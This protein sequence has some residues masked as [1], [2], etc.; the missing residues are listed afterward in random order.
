MERCCESIDEICNNLRDKVNDSYV[1]NN[2]ELLEII[3]DS[4]LLISSYR[5]FY[6][7]IMAL[8][9]ENIEKFNLNNFL[10]DTLE[11]YIRE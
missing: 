5:H 2:N 7:Q 3:T 8:I 1:F 9:D 10:D 11:E 6:R 4:N